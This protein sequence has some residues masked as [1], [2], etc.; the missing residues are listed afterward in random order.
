VRAG[1]ASLLTTAVVLSS[2]KDE[3]SKKV[4]AKHT[5]DG[6]VILVF[7]CWLEGSKLF[8]WQAMVNVV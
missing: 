4:T 2:H 7:F 1:G 8:Q 6:K 3:D 5:G